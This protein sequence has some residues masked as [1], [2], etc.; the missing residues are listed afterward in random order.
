VDGLLSQ[1]YGL[2][3]PPLLARVEWKERSTP[4]ANFNVDK[5]AMGAPTLDYE[6]ELGAVFV[7]FP[8]TLK[9]GHTYAIDFSHSGTPQTISRFGGFTTGTRFRTVQRSGDS[10]SA[11]ARA[12]P[13]VNKITGLVFHRF[14]HDPFRHPTVREE[15]GAVL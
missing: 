6:R 4:L 2:I 1:Y 5:T 9:T 14:D 15:Q 8:E 3:G 7:D 12:G 13:W 10:I 11:F